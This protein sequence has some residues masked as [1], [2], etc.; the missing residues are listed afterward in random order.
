MVLLNRFEKMIR[1]LINA[2]VMQVQQARK[3]EMF[4]Q[5]APGIGP[6][7]PP[8]GNDKL[9]GFLLGN[10]L[11]SGNIPW[12]KEHQIAM[13]VVDLIVLLLVTAGI[14][15][16]SKYLWNN[17]AVHLLPVKKCT[18]LKHLLGLFALAELF[19]N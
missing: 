17:A 5:G 7:V 6:A 4:R 19:L 15:F 12:V 3:A 9:G 1:D 16:G 11:I 2:I 13:V 10:D 18:N 14:L 8:R